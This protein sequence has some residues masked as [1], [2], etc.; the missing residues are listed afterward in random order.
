MTT[1]LN[2]LLEAN[3]S[4]LFLML[5]YWA[6]LRNENQFSFKR[7]FLLAAILCSVLLP[8]LNFN[9]SFSENVIPSITQIMPTTWLPS[10]VIGGGETTEQQAASGVGIWKALETLYFL[11]I[12]LLS[13]IF[14]VRLI[15]ISRL[16]LQS[17]K[18]EWNN[19]LV[20]ESTEEKSTFSFFHFIFIGQAHLLSEREKH[21]IL[22]HES[23]HVQKKHSFDIV[24]VNLIGII[25]WFNPIVRLYKKE[26]V[27]VHEFE[28]DAKTV[29][30]KD[31]DQYCGLL[32]KVALQK[33]NYP[34]ANH[35]NQSLTT[36]RIT[37]MKTMKQKI[38]NWKVTAL[39]FTSALLFF[40]IACNDQVSQDLKKVTQNS[41]ASLIL[42]LEVKGQ[43]QQLQLQNPAKEYTVIE[44]NEEGRKTLDKLKFGNAESTGLFSA[45]HVIR[46]DI[47][48]EGEGR[49]YVI[50]EKNSTT[51]LI[52]NATAVD[53][54]FTIVEESAT[55]KDG[56]AAF[57]KF[58]SANMKYPE[59]AR[60]AK[61]EGKLFVEFFINTD[62]SLSNFKIIK[63][64][65]ADC[66]QEVI[67]ILT[68]SP[69]WN[70]GK[71]RGK[72]VKQRMV[73]PFVFSLAFKDQASISSDQVKSVNENLEVAFVNSQV[74]GKAMLKGIVS[75]K[76][77]GSPIAGVNVVLKNSTIGTVTSSDGA[78][79]FESPTANGT[80]VFSFVGF[81][82]HEIEF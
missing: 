77:N 69:P 11:L 9:G 8:V 34:L 58:V 45:M 62:G 12:V 5:I 51:N 27:Q 19:C 21:E 65:S 10:I 4:L 35:F 66:D 23:F 78:F 6:L 60:S 70:P 36:K 17:K 80:L 40:V 14:L 33:I 41:S 50:L 61:T 72:A 53:E 13:I 38:K 39:V 46:T 59:S 31:V 15:G 63:S 7:I 32:A 47:H 37:M 82:M 71:Q 55:P 81:K 48:S 54:V 68:M 73:M 57:Y 49:S 75:N 26:L 56:I 67:R 18:Y 1:F 22:T 44:M 20:A 64:L 79:D 52:A 25:F 30:N 16:W 42:P 76:S 29:E 43:L 74:N 24:L 3:L 28:A 2:Y